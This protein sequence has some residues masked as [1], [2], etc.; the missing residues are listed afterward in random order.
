M[1]FELNDR[2]EIKQLP[3]GEFAELDFFG[4][5]VG[6]ILTVQDIDMEEDF[7]YLVDIDGRSVGMDGWFSKEQIQFATTGE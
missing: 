6:D 2:I 3:T 4:V 1:K 7:Y 5:K